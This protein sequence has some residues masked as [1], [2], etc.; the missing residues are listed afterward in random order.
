MNGAAMSAQGR[1]VAGQMPNKRSGRMEL[2][3]DH[4]EE[5]RVM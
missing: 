1:E 3:E 2:P 5:L 4:G